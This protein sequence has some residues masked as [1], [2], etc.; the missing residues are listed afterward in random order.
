MAEKIYL[1]R[2]SAKEIETQYGP[3]LKLGLHVD[4][5]IKFL[6]EHANNAGYVNFVVSRR[7]S[8]GQHG[9]THS[10]AL[11]NWKPQQGGQRPQR[12]AK[13]PAP[14]QADSPAPD[15]SDDQVPF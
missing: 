9:D 12:Q 6:K 8:P 2:S 13:A 4:E 7:R 10:V 5:T 15:A 1:P 11:D 3:M 14:A